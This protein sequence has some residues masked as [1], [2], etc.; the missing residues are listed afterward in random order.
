MDVSRQISWIENQHQ[1]LPA[2]FVNTT[3]AIK[4]TDVADVVTEEESKFNLDNIN[5]LYVAFTRAAEALFCL[6]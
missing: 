5:L 4:Y 2:F 3:N 1:K 6:F